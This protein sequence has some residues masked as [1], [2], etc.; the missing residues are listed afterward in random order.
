MPKD[1]NKL[2]AEQL[3]KI[4][5]AELVAEKAKE[6]TVP[7]IALELEEARQAI[8]AVAS[9]HVRL[10]A[11]QPDSFPRELTLAVERVESLAKALGLKVLEEMRK[12]SGQGLQGQVA[13]ALSDPADFAPSP[14]P[15]PPRRPPPAPPMEKPQ[16]RACTRTAGVQPCGACGLPFCPTHNDPALHPCGA[17]EE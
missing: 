15:P 4:T 8:I 5:P 12:G 16:C 9:E 13:E 6:K 7:E 11:G 1:P 14:D 2:L 10:C 3:E 17:L